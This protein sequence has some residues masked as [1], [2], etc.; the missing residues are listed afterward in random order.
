MLFKTLLS[1][2]EELR[3]W[4]ISNSE[5]NSIRRLLMVLMSSLMFGGLFDFLKK[6]SVD[7][8]V[9]IKM[10]ILWGKDSGRGMA[11]QE[12]ID[13]FEKQNPNI[14]VEL[15]GGTQ[16]NQKL[17]TMVLSGQ[18]PEVIQ[19]PYRGVKSLGKEG[20]FYDLTDKFAKEKKN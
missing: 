8:N 12:I 11:I 9:S 18:A 14:N 15:E 20:V 7:K 17:L 6:K 10:K 19:V 5:D 16:S 13:E 2:I 1:S 4:L 3:I